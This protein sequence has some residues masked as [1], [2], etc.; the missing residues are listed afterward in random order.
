MTKINDDDKKHSDI[1][2]NSIGL[3]H[4]YSQ[5]FQNFPMCGIEENDKRIGSHDQC[6]ASIRRENASS[7]DLGEREASLNFIS[8]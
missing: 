8:K 5:G 1:W 2:F 4:L 7:D 3:E 6:N